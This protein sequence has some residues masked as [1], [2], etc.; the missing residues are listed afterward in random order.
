MEQQ[1]VLIVD[2]EKFNRHAVRKAMRG[3]PVEVT[4]AEHGLEALDIMASHRFDLVLLDLMMPGMTGFEVLEELEKKQQLDDM[5]VIILTALQDSGEKVRALELGA[6]DYI[7]KPFVKAELL[8][9]VKLHLSLRRYQQRI[10]RHADE[11]EEEVRARTKELLDTQDVVSFSLARLAESRD[12]E[13]G[14]HLER[15]SRYSEVLAAEIVKGGVIEAISPDLP[16]MLRK[17]AVLHDIGKVG[18]P[19]AILL[20]PGKLT[21][22]EFEKMKEHTI[23]GGDTLADANSR[24]GNSVGYLKIAA[25]IAYYHHEKW[26]GRGYPKGLAGNDIP[27]S[28]RIVALAD[29]YDAL[30]SKRVYKPSF[31]HEKSRSIILEQRGSHFQ[32][33]VVDAFLACEEIFLEISERFKPVD[34]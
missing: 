27:L 20:K 10:S 15:M 1:K 24:L 34:E 18:I 21:D 17:V 4:L 6:V 5:S 29:V 25:D 13:T 7:I 28:S 23:Y 26:N 32:P 19:D 3:L 2:D 12:P 14:D 9:R 22:E 16:S 33:E 30:R 31:S 11:L 8:A